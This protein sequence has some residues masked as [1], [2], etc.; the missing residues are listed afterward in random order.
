MYACDYFECVPQTR[1]YKPSQD[2]QEIERKELYGR[3]TSEKRIRAKASLMRIMLS[4][5]R[6]VAVIT[7]D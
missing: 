3:T 6:G 5:C 1:T 7:C 2:L 4:N